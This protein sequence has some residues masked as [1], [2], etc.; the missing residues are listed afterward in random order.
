[1]PPGGL[2]HQAEPTRRRCC[3]AC[4]AEDPE[5]RPTARQVVERLTHIITASKKVISPRALSAPPGML[6]PRVSMGRL[7]GV[8]G[9]RGA[10]D[11]ADGTVHFVPQI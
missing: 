1:M 9:H 3:C 7:E 8:T 5:A 2:H 10:E 11:G 6:S 4:C